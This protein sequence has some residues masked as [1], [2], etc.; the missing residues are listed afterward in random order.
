MHP[1][2][3]TTTPAQKPAFTSDYSYIDY[4]IEEFFPHQ[5]ARG[6]KQIG[7]LSIATRADGS[8][9]RLPYLAI[10]G[11]ESG[12]TLLVL[13][14]IHGDE[15]EGM[16]AIP[17]IFH[18]LSP[19]ELRGT[20]IMAPLCNVAAFEAGQRTSP[21]DDLNLARVF[22]GDPVGTIT[23]RIAY[24]IGQRLI[25]QADLLID[26]HS[27][28]TDADIPTLIG[29]I[30]DDGQVGKR[31]LAA[32]EAFGAPVLWG[33]PLPLPAGRTISLATDLGIPALYTETPGGGRATPDDVA[34]YTQGV[35]N[36]LHHLESIGRPPQRMPVT[37][38][39]FGD[40][41]LDQVISAPT[42]GRFLNTVELLERVEQGQV[43]GEIHDAFGRVCTTLQAPRAGVVILLRRKRRVHV[44]EGLIQ[45]TGELG[46]G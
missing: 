24:W 46:G 21:I 37:H 19:H 43:V 15:Y 28:S 9:W 30:H 7:H 20:L 1:E 5:I 26:L 35:L 3:E 41:N 45:I 33:H 34:C 14:G 10:T 42:A 22:P 25:S 31:S 44:G 6:S 8:S 18:G 36:V 32:A 11:N 38:H 13:A 12:P 39:L 27:G 29:Y 17:R 2:P 16:E 4:P 40:G 23:Q